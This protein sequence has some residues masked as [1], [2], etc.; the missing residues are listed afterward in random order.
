MARPKP[1]PVCGHVG[2]ENEDGTCPNNNC[3]RH[4]DAEVLGLHPATGK[5][6]KDADE[7]ATAV[8]EHKAKAKA[9]D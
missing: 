4:T 2:E 3:A 7:L 6:V 1:C 5:P 9:E 8:A